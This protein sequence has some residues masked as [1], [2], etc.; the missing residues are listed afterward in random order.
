M[1]R[2]IRDIADDEVIRIQ[3]LLSQRHKCSCFICVR[4]YLVKE[5]NFSLAKQK[6]RHSLSS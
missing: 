2:Y 6:P 4:K 1:G 3:R 5:R